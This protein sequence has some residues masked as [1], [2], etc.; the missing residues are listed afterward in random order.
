MPRLVP[1]ALD[2]TLHPECSGVPSR[3]LLAFF[4]FLFRAAPA[5]YGISRLRVILE[6]QLLAY[7]TA[8]SNADPKPTEQGQGLNA[9]PLGY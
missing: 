8:H 3:L 5:E 9:H 4:F 2:H 1:A 7:T 6:L